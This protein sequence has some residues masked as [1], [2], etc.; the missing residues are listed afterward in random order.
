V[1]VYV[2]EAWGPHFAFHAALPASA[3]QSGADGA[4]CSTHKVLGAITQSAVLNVRGGLVAPD[5]VGTLVGM[6]QTTSPAV[7]IMASIDACRRQM[8]LQGRELLDRTIA[9]AEEARRRLRAVPGVSVLG[10]DLLG[11]SDDRYDPTKLV[12]DVHGLGLTGFEVEH[13]LR[14][15]Y[16]INPE[17]SDLVGIECLITVGD[18]PA[19]IERLVAAFE[20][21]ATEGAGYPL[22]AAQGAQ[23]AQEVGAALRS[24]GAVI[25][26]GEQAMSPREAFFAEKRAVPLAESVGCVAAELVIPYP[27]GI[28]VLAPGDVISADKIEYLRYGAARGMYVSGP[29]D[30]TLATVRVVV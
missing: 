28:P 10:A 23:G 9:L 7:L 15:R 20:D 8:V 30:E 24:S 6:V 11:L 3:M 1:P 16:R 14:E 26:A 29:A 4:V 17:M 22:G 27:P 13:L 25:A 12:I 19:S 21:M 5:H 18:T 2:D